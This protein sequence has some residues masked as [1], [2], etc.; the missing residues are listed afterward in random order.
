MAMQTGLFQSAAILI[1]VVLFYVLDFLSIAR[2]DRQRQA[3]GSGR[4]WDY[5]LFVV[6]MIALVV[7]QPVVLPGLGLRIEAVWG[8]LLQIVGLILV[9]A[10]LALHTWSRVC[11]RE[12]YAER[13]E[14]QPGHTVI[15]SGPYAYVRHPAFTSFFLFVIGFLL[16]NPALPTLLLALYAFW[17]F[18]R[19]ARQEEDLLSGSLPGYSSYMQRTARFVPRL[20]QLRGER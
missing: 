20:S 14:L 16:I 12:Y 3:E 18:T 9:V 4:S 19:A 7:A 1:V 2:Y 8:L 17:D 5:L 11:L 10:G 15:D 13:V 6:I